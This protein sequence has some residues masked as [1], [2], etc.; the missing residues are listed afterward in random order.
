ME[1]S[2]EFKLGWNMATQSYIE[3]W[4]R[5]IA[6]LPREEVIEHFDTFITMCELR[7][8]GASWQEMLMVAELRESPFAEDI[9]R[10]IVEE[11]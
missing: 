9:R 4:Q 8:N 6:T 1:D 7:L 3:I 5:T 10:F 11:G 2:L